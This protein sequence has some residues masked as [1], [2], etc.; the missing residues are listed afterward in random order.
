V[1]SR[2]HLPADA[3][4][5]WANQHLLHP[6]LLSQHFLDQHLLHQ[7]LVTQ[8]RHDQARDGQP[9]N[10]PEACY[11]TG[12]GFLDQHL[13]HQQLLT[14]QRHT[15][16]LSNS[17]LFST[18][19][20]VVGLGLDPRLN[21]PVGENT[22]GGPVGDNTAGGPV[23]ENTAGG[24][25]G[26]NTAGGLVGENTAGGLIGGSTA[27]G[28]VRG[29]TAGGLVGENTAGGLVAGGTA[30]VDG[31]NTAG[32]VCHPDVSVSV[33][34][35]GDVDTPGSPRQ[36]DPHREWERGG[37]HALVKLENGRAN[38]RETAHSRE[39][40]L[41][42]IEPRGA[43]HSLAAAEARLRLKERQ[44]NAR[45][46]EAERLLAEVLYIYVYIYIYIQIYI[47]I[48]IYIYMFIYIY[49]YIYIYY[50]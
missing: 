28:L 1:E 48:Y 26:E 37:M 33:P 16:H 50:M 25:V 35:A 29:S 10:R 44:V 8:Q 34:T 39:A 46:V 27:G 38:G 24:P 3:D 23:G 49:I 9:L 40:E 19:L 17:E 5:D 4:A 7:Q 18:Q 32:E 45:M 15:Q 6:P 47:Y 14:Q 11:H 20:G 43:E 12:G 30:G 41:A 2:D 36:S 13:L 31:A 22:A 21:R 42:R